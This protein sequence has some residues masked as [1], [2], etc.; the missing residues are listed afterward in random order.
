MVL[1]KGK[2]GAFV[3]RYINKWVCP[4]QRFLFHAFRN[5]LLKLKTLIS[6]KFRKTE[7]IHS[8]YFKFKKQEEEMRLRRET[9]R[10]KQDRSM[11]ETSNLLRNQV[12]FTSHTQTHTQT[13]K[14]T[15]KQTNTH[16]HTHTH[17]HT[18]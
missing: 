14:H 5:Q 3:E 13:H 12:L 15:N 17:T 4:I 2:G 6:F 11:R 8:Y 7:K 9:E 10:E 18:E 16:T 1:E